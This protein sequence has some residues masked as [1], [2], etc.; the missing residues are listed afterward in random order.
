MR[1]RGGTAAMLFSC[2][3]NLMLGALIAWRTGVGAMALR[4]VG[5]T[6][7]ILGFPVWIAQALMRT[8]ASPMRTCGC[9]V[10][11]ATRCRQKP[12]AGPSGSVSSPPIHSTP[13]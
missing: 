5:E 1:A 12:R 2:G 13:P 9:T 4:E 3:L 10:S 6:S 11:I 7:A 8:A